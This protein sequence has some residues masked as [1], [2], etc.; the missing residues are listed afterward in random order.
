MFA[1]AIVKECSATLRW[2]FVRLDLTQLGCFF[3]SCICLRLP[4]IV[5]SAVDILLL[6]GSGG[7]SQSE[8]D[9][10]GHDLWKVLVG[11]PFQEIG[12]LI[13]ICVVVDGHLL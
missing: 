7:D 9:E 8:G 6:E 12:P 13:G 3:F 5:P 10:W 4:T 2:G 1:R 11:T